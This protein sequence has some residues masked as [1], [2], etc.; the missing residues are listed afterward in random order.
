M[1]TAILLLPA[2][3]SCAARA[4]GDAA[5]TLYGAWKLVSTE[6]RLAG[7]G[8]RPMPNLGPSAVGYLHY[9]PGHR[10]CAVLMNP[11]RG[12][13]RALS[14]GKATDAELAAAARGF[15]AVCGRFDVDEREGIVTHHGEID[16]FPSGLG[17]TRKRRFAL[18]GDRLVL[19]PLPP[20]PKG[21]V[22]V[23]LTWERVRD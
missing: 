3:F 13:W 6:Q 17:K 20:F 21:V 16:L 5:A 19:R 11:D 4:Q 1:R 18:S 23:S 15:F 8:A 12:P 14:V 7:G 10:M 22:G 2:L 9:A